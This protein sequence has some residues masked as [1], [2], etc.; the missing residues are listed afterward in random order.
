MYISFGV[1]T[2][3]AGLASLIHLLRLGGKT[4]TM[5]ASK[6][7]LKNV[8]AALDGQRYDDAVEGARKILQ[9]EKDNY[10]A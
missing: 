3:G 5:A 6:A 2:S 1:S 4:V 9:A 8:K 10:H 7:A